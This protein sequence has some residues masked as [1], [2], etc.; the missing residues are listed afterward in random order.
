MLPP[1]HVGPGCLEELWCPAK[2]VVPWWPSPCAAVVAHVARRDRWMAVSPSFHCITSQ[3][4]QRQIT[5]PPFYGVRDLLDHRDSAGLGTLKLAGRQQPDDVLTCRE[6]HVAGVRVRRKDCKAGGAGVAPVWPLTTCADPVRHGLETLPRGE[7][8]HHEAPQKLV[9]GRV[10]EAAL[11]VHVADDSSRVGFAVLVQKLQRKHLVPKG[12]VS[13]VLALATAGA[14]WP[15]ELPTTG[16]P[17]RE[18]GVS[19]GE[20]AHG[21]DLVPHLGAAQG[22]QLLRDNPGRVERQRG[23]AG[24]AVA[25]QRRIDVVEHVEHN[26]CTCGVAGPCAEAG[27]A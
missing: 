4:H 13:Q 23:M 9:H 22:V 2:R 8:V 3:P 6:P 20:V 11:C 16:W 5:G 1:V 15:E 17:G 24:G 18:P 7:T 10:V 19:D 26:V 14:L 12:M 27:L 21:R 25:L